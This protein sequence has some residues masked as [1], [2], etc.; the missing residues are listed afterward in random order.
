MIWIKNRFDLLVFIIFFS[1]RAFTKLVGFTSVPCLVLPNRWN[2][3]KDGNC[4]Q[5]LLSKKCFACFRNK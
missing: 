1:L 5:G 4:C 2:A 3:L